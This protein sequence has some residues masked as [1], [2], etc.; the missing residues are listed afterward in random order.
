MAAILS[1]TIGNQDE[2]AAIFVGFPIFSFGMV[3]AMAIAIAMT[4]QSK[5]KPLEIRTSKLV[6]PMCLVFQC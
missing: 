3:G 5:T 6:N 1:K 4:G 2:I